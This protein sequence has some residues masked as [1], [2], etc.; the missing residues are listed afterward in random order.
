MNQQL[1]LSFD[2]L[3][4][5]SVL[6]TLADVVAMQNAQ[7]IAAM[8]LR[9]GLASH[10]TSFS[11]TTANILLKGDS[12]PSVS[13]ELLSQAAN[14]LKQNLMD[15][16]AAWDV[17]Q[18]VKATPTQAARFTSMWMPKVPVA[19]E[20][21]FLL[22][23]KE[24]AAAK[25]KTPE[26]K[27]DNGELARKCATFATALVDAYIRAFMDTIAEFVSSSSWTAVEKRFTDLTPTVLR[28][29]IP[30]GPTDKVVDTLR[31]HA[32]TA[33]RIKC[34]DSYLEIVRFGALLNFTPQLE[35][36]W[37]E[38]FSRDLTFS[39]T[40]EEHLAS[41]W[42]KLSKGLLDNTEASLVYLKANVN[43]QKRGVIGSLVTPG[44]AN[45]TATSAATA[46]TA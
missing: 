36:H 5:S 43:L 32:V 11:A 42:A 40:W 3:G 34:N 31:L 45:A 24:K 28:Q 33:G 39:T 41:Q 4:E 22:P 7:A 26:P 1:A 27:A 29:P 15:A 23:K 9:K 30:F 44:A 2:V 17:T 25:E 6:P 20:K 13:K 10:T 12:N 21:V 38:G 46:A 18:V 8:T 35:Q 19:A 14:A 16:V 37:K